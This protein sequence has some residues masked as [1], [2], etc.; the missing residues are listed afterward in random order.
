MILSRKHPAQ[1]ARMMPA[2]MPTARAMAVEATAEEVLLLLLEPELEPPLLEPHEVARLSQRKA[3]CMSTHAPLEA[4]HMQLLP[5][6]QL[7]QDERD[8][9]CKGVLMDEPAEHCEESHA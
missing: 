2:A 3:L 7:E 8:E 1:H 9:H 4:H 5:V 6:L